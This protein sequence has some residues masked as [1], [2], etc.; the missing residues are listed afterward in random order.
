MAG[1]GSRPFARLLPLLLNWAAVVRTVYGGE[2][3]GM[4]HL[5]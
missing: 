5:W 4:G 3:R 1:G 2:V